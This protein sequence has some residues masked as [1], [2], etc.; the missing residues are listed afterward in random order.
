MVSKYF[1]ILYSLFLWHD[2]IQCLCNVIKW[3]D[4]SGMAR[5]FTMLLRTIHNLKCEL[6]YL[7]IFHLI[8]LDLSWP[9]V[10]GTVESKAVDKGGLLYSRSSLPSLSFYLF[11]CPLG[12][13][14]WISRLIKMPPGW[15]H[16]F[17][18]KIGQLYVFNY[19]IPTYPNKFTCPH[20]I[21]Y[22]VI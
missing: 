5:E 11:C 20:L 10:T 18:H 16:H 14:T 4:D 8:F 19:G 21:S 7:G 9:W 17:P 1:I 3:G 6:F 2:M 15:T 12:S 13:L 22:Y